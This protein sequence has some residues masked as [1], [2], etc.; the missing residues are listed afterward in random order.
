MVLNIIEL[1]LIDMDYDV[2]EMG[3][4]IIVNML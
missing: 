2:V 1:V 3:L 4:K